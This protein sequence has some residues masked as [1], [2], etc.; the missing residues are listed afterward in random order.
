MYNVEV[1]NSEFSE[2]SESSE[3]ILPRFFHSEFSILHHI[4]NRKLGDENVGDFLWGILIK[5]WGFLTPNF[6]FALHSKRKTQRWKPQIFSEAVWSNSEVF[7]LRVFGLGY[8]ARTKP[9]S[10]VLFFNGSKLLE[11]IWS[12]RSV[13][14]YGLSPCINYMQYP[15]VISSVPVSHILSTCESYPQYPWL[16]SS[17]PVSH[18]L[19]TRE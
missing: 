6:P 17:V 1:E 14:L 13:T 4:Q 18:I 12:K 5:L 10:N 7:H 2:I 8:S 16:I 15:W 3:N 11:K 9:R 19:S